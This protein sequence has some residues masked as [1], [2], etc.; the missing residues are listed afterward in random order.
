MI[1]NSKV[2]VKL[3][4]SKTKKNLSKL[5]RKKIISTSFTLLKQFL[6][7]LVVV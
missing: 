7:L 5:I 1:F 3:H 2:L 6:V 4:I